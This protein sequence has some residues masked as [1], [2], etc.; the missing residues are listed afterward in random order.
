MDNYVLTKEDLINLS[1]KIYESGCF[2]YLDLKDSI[3]ET[4]IDEFLHNN[5]QKAQDNSFN[6]VLG[7]NSFSFSS[8]PEYAGT[9]FFISSNTTDF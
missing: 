9:T 5:K 3:C 4:L 6:K 1:H 7:N 8:V 2:G